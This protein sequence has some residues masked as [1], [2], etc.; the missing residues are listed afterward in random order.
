MILEDISEN[1]LRDTGCVDRDGRNW[2]K[3]A[4][5]GAF[6]TCSVQSLD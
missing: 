3:F 2:L 5:N 4:V 6:G 1:Q